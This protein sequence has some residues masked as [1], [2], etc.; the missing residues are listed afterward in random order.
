LFKKVV[1]EIAK[2][3]VG[4]SG[5]DRTDSSGFKLCHT[6]KCDQYSAGSRYE[7]IT[8]YHGTKT[9]YKF[10]RQIK[11]QPQV[12]YTKKLEKRIYSYDK[13]LLGIID[14]YIDGNAGFE[15][16]IT[17]WNATSTNPNAEEPEVDPSSKHLIRS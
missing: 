4:E 15:Y 3:I 12:H 10:Q 9:V 13:S 14:C 5:D 11:P 1:L 16:E 8:H 2:T 7:G 6:P 17:S